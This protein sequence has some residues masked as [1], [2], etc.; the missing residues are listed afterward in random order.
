MQRPLNLVYTAICG[1][2][3]S[4]SLRGS[5]YFLMIVDDHSKLIWVVMLTHKSDALATFKWFK[6]LIETE[7]E[8]KI[9]CLWIDRGSEFRLEEFKAFCDA[10]GV[11]HQL[12][13]PYT[14]QH[15][16]VV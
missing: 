8:T 1:P 6:A 2:I 12:M 9:K 5:N 14:P 15:N 16:G 4:A 3:S 7:K 10:N 11:R 13:A